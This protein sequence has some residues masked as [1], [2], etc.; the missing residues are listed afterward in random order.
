MSC[1]LMMPKYPPSCL[2]KHTNK[3]VVHLTQEC[4]K[5]LLLLVT[6]LNL[7]TIP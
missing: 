4:L 5:Q 7:C 1:A 3:A 2:M 6:P